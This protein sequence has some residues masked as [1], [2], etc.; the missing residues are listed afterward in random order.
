MSEFDRYGQANE[1]VARDSR[2][3]ESVVGL[4]PPR[5]ESGR[6]VCLSGPGSFPTVTCRGYR[7]SWPARPVRIDRRSAGYVLVVDGVAVDLHRFGHLL[8]AARAAHV[9]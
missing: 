5:P 1:R 2:R 9:G 3:V 6:T 8:A 7:A 4:G